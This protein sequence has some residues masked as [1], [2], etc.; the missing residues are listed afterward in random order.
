MIRITKQTLKA[1]IPLTEKIPVTEKKYKIEGV[2]K[3]CLKSCNIT[4]MV[5]QKLK[6]KTT[7]GKSK[8]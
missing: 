7:K 4:A 3:N 5:N 6:I 2:H 1:T 8:M